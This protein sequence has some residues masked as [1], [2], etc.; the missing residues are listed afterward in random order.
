M[1]KKR[2]ES[3]S[4]PSVQEGVAPPSLLS[5]ADN[6]EERTLLLWLFD[7]SSSMTVDCPADPDDPRSPLTK[8]IAELNKAIPRF[9]REILARELLA[10]QV[11]VATVSFATDVAA[12]PF[13]PVG[14]WDPP[15][16]EAAGGTA[17][18]QAILAG[19]DVL[20][21]RLAELKA[22]GVP[23]RHVMAALLSDGD[24]TSPKPDK[25]DEAARRVQGLEA[26]GGFDFFAVGVQHPDLTRLAKYSRKRP[27]VLLRGLRFAEMFRWFAASAERIS[28]SRPRERVALP[29][30]DAWASIQR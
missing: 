23:V 30:I 1:P 21:R 16:L 4:A 9:R 22:M 27:P 12:L 20:E 26:A 15:V 7:R 28:M 8:P 3:L 2:L 10:L 6:T 5:G 25:T 19:I 13:T 29:P 11:E 17:L 18:G 24:D 14:G